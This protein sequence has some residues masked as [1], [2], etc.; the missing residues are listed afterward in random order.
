MG[1]REAAFET[2]MSARR[3]E[4]HALAC[5]ALR[6]RLERCVT[7]GLRADAIQVG[8]HLVALDPLCEDAHRQL[9][10]LYHETGDRASPL[11][12]YRDCAEVLE[13]ELDVEPASETARL[14]E[15]IKGRNG[16]SGAGDVSNDSR[17][18][19]GIDAA[20]PSGMGNKPS[21]AVLP[22]ANTGGDRESDY[23][24]DGVTEDII[25][26][27]SRFPDVLVIAHNSTLVYKHRAVDHR[28]I[29]QDLG[30]RFVLEGSVRRGGKRVRITAQ[31]VDASTGN[32]L[33]AERFDRTLD[34]LFAVQDQITATIV[35]TLGDAVQV[36][37]MRR[38]MGRDPGSLDAYD[39]CLQ[40]WARR[41][42]FGKENNAEARRLAKEAIELD[43]DCA[44]A[45]AILSG[46]HL[47]DFSSHWT[48]EPDRA[49]KLSYEA[50]RKAVSLD[51]HSCY[52]YR[53]LG[54]AETWLGRHDRAVAS[55]R[56]AI[57]LNPNEADTRAYFANI[58]VFAGRADDALEELEIAMRLNPR[59]PNWYLQF[60]GRAC[61]AQRRYQEAESAFE[62]VVT[63]SP[64]WP[65]AHLI[66]GATRIALGRIEEAKAEVAEALRLS[67]ALTL[68]HVPRAWPFRNA[69]DLERLVGLLREAGLPEQADRGARV[70]NR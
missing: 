50:A 26:E 57:E 41:N 44:R 6:S 23:F 21:I 36:E 55:F 7:D 33:W 19:L 5:E 66:L 61:F 35:S 38:A 25:T 56:R 34:D 22:F 52:A 58:L 30:V 64:G 31:L 27:L 29:A 10:R 13:R 43:P 20:G 70:A 14:V 37:H 16:G 18:L 54:Q 32:H 48:D 17:H 8:K 51:D 45:Y 12:Q 69:A 47:M 1:I 42:R 3:S 60:L 15:E 68:G 67:P 65:W 11:R 40:A 9:M 28:Q 59:Y 49:L 62:R 46:T 39:K 53:N 63:V 24:S 4:F 2:W